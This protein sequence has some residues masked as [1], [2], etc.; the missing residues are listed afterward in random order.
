MGWSA[1]GYRTVRV[2][3]WGLEA[4][5]NDGA[6]WVL[7]GQG[8]HISHLSL[9]PSFV[10]IVML[11]VVYFIPGLQPRGIGDFITQTAMGCGC[12]GLCGFSF[13]SI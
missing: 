3:E 4:E 9:G 1:G 11:T 2:T 8:H 13:N 6:W 5:S 7:D 10:L 12:R